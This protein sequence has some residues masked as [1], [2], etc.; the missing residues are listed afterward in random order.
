VQQGATTKGSGGGSNVT[1]LSLPS[2]PKASSFDSLLLMQLSSS[3]FVA[4]A[5]AAFVVSRATPVIID[6]REV[7]REIVVRKAMPEFIASEAMPEFVSR[8]ANNTKVIKRRTE[9]H[10]IQE[11]WGGY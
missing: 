6:P 2:L 3:S 9:R 1:S 4:L 8:V 7:T 10:W 11:K 5:K